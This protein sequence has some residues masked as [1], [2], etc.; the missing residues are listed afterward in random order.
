MAYLLTAR[1]IQDAPSFRNWEGINA[2]RE[3]L[4][5]QFQ[6]MIQFSSSSSSSSSSDFIP[7]HRLL[8]LLNQSVSYQVE[9]NKVKPTKPSV[10]SL[11]QDFETFVVP[12]VCQRTFS[13]HE[14]NV[15]CAEWVGDRIL[16]G[17]S[18]TKIIIWRNSG[19]KVGTLE[20]HH[21]R[22]WELSANR[23]GTVCVSGSADGLMKVL[24]IHLLK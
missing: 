5:D 7:P 1:S 16:S 19:E 14:G 11:L 8:T 13:G 3:K 24:Q 12:N 20:G 4:L 23:L 15:K 6:N 18:D 22:I 17:S 9:R 21:G 10:G 2:S